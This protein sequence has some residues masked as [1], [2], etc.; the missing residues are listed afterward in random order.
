MRVRGVF[1]VFFIMEF[2]MQIPVTMLPASQDGGRNDLVFTDSINGVDTDN[3]T[4]GT[5]VTIFASNRFNKDAH[6][7]QFIESSTD[8]KKHGFSED[9]IAAK[10][11]H[12]TKLNDDTNQARPRDLP[13]FKRFDSFKGLNQVLSTNQI[14]SRIDPALD[15]INRIKEDLAR[16]NFKL[17][18]IHSQRVNLSTNLKNKENIMVTDN[19]RV[20]VDSPI[21][22]DGD[23]NTNNKDK[24]ITS[25]DQKQSQNTQAPT[26][27]GQNHRDKIDSFANNTGSMYTD[28]IVWSSKLLSKCPSGLSQ[29]EY[30]MWRNELKSLRVVKIEKGCGSLQNRLITFNDSSKACVRYRLNN[31]QMQGEIYSYYL[32]RLLKMGYTPPTILHTMNNSE[33]WT[34]VKGAIITANWS[35][36]RPIVVT[37]WVDSLEPV[38]MPNKLK[39]SKVK[40]DERNYPFQEISLQEACDLVQWS[41]LIVFDYISS[42]LDRVVNNMFNL[43]WNPRMLDKPIHNLEKS[44]KTGQYVFLD[45]ESGLFHGYRLVDTYEIYHEQLLSSVCIF[46]QTTLDR[47]QDLLISGSAGDKLQSLYE[48]NEEFSNLLPKMTSKNK[49]IL[50]T[51]IE[52]VLKHVQMCKHEVRKS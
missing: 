44:A 5:I 47:L 43:Q 16:A 49:K 51:R 41:D 24:L 14:N 50:Q 15:D 52:K 25:P 4:G 11:V 23:D 13:D 18:Q 22:A 10:P 31:D 12:S 32:G 39:D 26:E 9:F 48:T 33:Q 45:N 30:Q 19:T 28:G 42:N 3:R 27:Y 2:Q 34:E 20:L 7:R 29:N 17:K 40:L 46:K 37:K 8:A 6:P 21:I 36:K 38:F 1:I 35:E